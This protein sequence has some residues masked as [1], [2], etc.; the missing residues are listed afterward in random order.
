[1]PPT[2]KNNER[3]GMVEMFLSGSGQFK[4][5]FDCIEGEVHNGKVLTIPRQLHN[6]EDKVITLSKHCVSLSLLTRKNLTNLID[7]KPD[8][9]LIH[10]QDINKN[11]KK[12]L[13]LCISAK[14]PYKNYYSS[15][16]QFP[17]GTNW[18]DYIE[19]LKE[20]MYKLLSNEERKQMLNMLDKDDMPNKESDEVYVEQEHEDEAANA[21]D[22]L[23]ID[24][25]SLDESINSSKK[26]TNR[27]K[28]KS[29]KK[30]SPK[31]NKSGRRKKDDDSSYTESG[32]LSGCSDASH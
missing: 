15:G 11:C 9:L 26:S 2:N 27:K 21:D 4:G 20:E 12:A 19:W 7:I 5:L 29:G 14:S 32:S 6:I 25:V 1:M 24:N 28:K 31:K 8:R 22:G 17:S 23:D 18:V 10:V 30:N 13:R 3:L 16:C